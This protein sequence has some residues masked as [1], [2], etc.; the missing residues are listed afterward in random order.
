MGTIKK[1]AKEVVA[2]GRDAAVR[3]GKVAKSAAIAGAKAGASAAIVAGTLEAQ[4]TWKETSPAGKK[5]TR[6]G[7]AAVLAGVAV[8]G[9]VGVV[10]AKSRKKS[11]TG[12]D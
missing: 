8:L 9:A 3:V 4:R 1:S 6:N 12:R 2:S 7:V 11:T 10:I 5:R